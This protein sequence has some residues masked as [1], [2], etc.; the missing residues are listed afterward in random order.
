MVFALVS[1][2]PLSKPLEGKF[3]INKINLD[4]FIDTSFL[5]K[6]SKILASIP[7]N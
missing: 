2:T 4:I 6:K 7:Q 1:L 5:W 3:T